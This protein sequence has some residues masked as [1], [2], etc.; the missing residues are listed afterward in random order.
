MALHP[1]ETISQAQEFLRGLNRKQQFTLGAGE[2]V[3]VLSLFVF[4]FLISKS[5]YT[6]LYSGLQP[7]EA[8]S[9]ART[10]AASNVPYEISSDGTSLRVPA[11]K[12]DSVR[13]D[14]PSQ[15][16]PQTGRLGLELFDSPIGQGASLLKGVNYPR[17]L[18]GELERTIRCWCHLKNSVLVGQGVAKYCK[19]N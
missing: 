12:L 13:L 1:R 10:L 11:S 15:G 9:I 18:E 5:D 17:A 3:V 2:C 19:E 16:L 7:E 4:V 14:L 6:P 8:Q